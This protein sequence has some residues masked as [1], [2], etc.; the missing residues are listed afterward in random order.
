[1]RNI[2]ERFWDADAGLFAD[3]LDHQHFS[4]HAQ[5][6]AVLGGLLD[7]AR[8]DSI[9]DRIDRRG[10][11]RTTV[12]FSHY[13]FEA[14]RK[15]K[16]PDLM[17]DRLEL[18]YSFRGMGLKTLLEA[19]EPSR[20]DCH[21]WS[22]HPLFH[23][24]ATILGIRPGAAG[25][26][27]VEIEPCLGDLTEAAGSIPHPSGG[28]IS[29]SIVKREECTAFRISLPPGIPGVLHWQGRRI[30]FSGSLECEMPVA[31]VEEIEFA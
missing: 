20:S 31:R 18:W 6:L 9:R 17:F 12:Y 10:I 22:S 25:F 28:A 1:M 16:R 24:Y 19:P 21:A 5:C 23:C 8:I 27:R 11:A 15:L 29:V 7:E 4:E 13:L 14:A 30:P 26:Q 3:T 2:V